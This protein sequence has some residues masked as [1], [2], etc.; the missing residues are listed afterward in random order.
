MPAITPNK[1]SCVVCRKETSQ[2][3]IETHYRRSHGSEKDKLAWTR[4]ITTKH[5]LRKKNTKEY[6][7]SPNRCKECN[8]A[9]PYDIKSNKFCSSSC[10][11]KHN[12][13][14]RIESGWVMSDDAKK[15]ISA[16]LS[17]PTY[18]DLIYGEYSRVYTRTC[19]FC[20][21][22]FMTNTRKQTCPTCIPKT[23]RAIDIFRF[24]FNVYDMPEL[25]DLSLVQKHGWFSQGGR[26][27]SKNTNGVSRDHRVSV[28]EALKNGYDHYYITHP[29]NCELM[30]HSD[31]NKKKGNSSISYQ[32]LIRIVDKYDSLR[33]GH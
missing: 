26:N 25:F 19:K 6:Y 12:N 13:K 5:D 10:A 30:L 14:E 3:G 28:S 8:D 21:T 22:P 16:K 11:A 18:S 17:K 2:L 29:L 24:K 9:L 27:K 33:G 31:N 20:K 1:C 23:H 32:E 7:D 15:S 4:S